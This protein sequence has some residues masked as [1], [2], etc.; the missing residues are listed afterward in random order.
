MD[1]QALTVYGAAKSVFHWKVDCG[2]GSTCPEIDAALT[3]SMSHKSDAPGKNNS[4]ARM[5][6]ATRSALEPQNCAKVHRLVEEAEQAYIEQHSGKW[7]K[8]GDG[9]GAI[10]GH[11]L[12]KQRS[13]R[14]VNKQQ[15]EQTASNSRS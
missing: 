10:R 8:W 12:R 7:P 1:G 4:A 3:V 2:G 5:T 6:A 14:K 9:G 15:G 11:I 13:V